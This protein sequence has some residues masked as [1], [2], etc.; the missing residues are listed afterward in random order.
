[1]K[2]SPIDTIRYVPF[3]EEERAPRCAL[4]RHVRWSCCT[5]VG[6]FRVIAQLL[7]SWLAEVKLN[8]KKCREL[9]KLKLRA[10]VNTR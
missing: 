3:Q 10:W 2:N 7:Q 9:G 8:A 6:G 4:S 5:G 1:M